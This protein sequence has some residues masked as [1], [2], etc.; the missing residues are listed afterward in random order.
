MW[1]GGGGG[2][3]GHMRLAWLYK[4]VMLLTLF[5]QSEHIY[6]P[7]LSLSPSQLTH[8]PCALV[9]AKVEKVGNGKGVCLSQCSTATPEGRQN[10]GTL[11]GRGNSGWSAEGYLKGIPYTNFKEMDNAYSKMHISPLSLSLSLP[12]SLSLSLPSE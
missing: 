7:S 1:G 9:S 11:S 2:G 5:C 8:C 6:S 10:S 3:R 12:L 4:S